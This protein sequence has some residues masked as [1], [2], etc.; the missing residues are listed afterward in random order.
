MLRIG[1]VSASSKQKPQTLT[2]PALV[3]SAGQIHGENFLF[4][5][6]SFRRHCLSLDQALRKHFPSPQNWQQ[7]SKH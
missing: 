2:Q 1:I 6:L 3:D 4:E 5:A 7:P